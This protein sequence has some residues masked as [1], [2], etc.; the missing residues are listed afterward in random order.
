MA[1]T[2]EHATSEA[3]E[4]YLI[5]IAMAVEDGHE[6]PVPIPYLGKKLE[7]SRVSANEMVKKLVDKGFVTYEPY[8]GVSLTLEG[9]RV[10]DD[11][12]RHRR[13][14]ALFLSDHLG[15]SPAAADV[16]ACEF[17]HIT[18]SEVAERL[19]HFLGDPSMGPSG[20]RIPAFGGAAPAA[21]TRTVL[22]ESPL[23]R[24]AIITGIGGDTAIR[25][26]LAEAGLVEGAPVQLV[27]VGEDRGCLVRGA[28]GNIHLTAEL[29]A[30]ISVE[31]ARETPRVG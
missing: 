24:P 10:A 12:L 11:V 18:P 27:A 30:S 26:F 8:K 2:H 22:S 23:G 13:L 3:E 7:V 21:I 5:T 6:G 9:E 29:A 15:L 20:K 25:S 4:M 28:N 1:T 16:V 14:W 19:Y 31:A 17:E